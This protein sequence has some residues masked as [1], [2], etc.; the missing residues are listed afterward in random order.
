[1]RCCER[2]FHDDYLQRYI[3]EHGCIGSCQFCRARRVHVMRAGDLND[4]F[5]RFTELYPR[6]EPGVNAPPDVDV[7]ERGE[8]LATI[9][10]EQWEIFSDR[11][12]E[13]DAH[14]DLLNKIYTENCIEEDILDAPDMHE[15]Y[16]ERNWLHDSLLDQWHELAEELKHPEEHRPFAPELEPSE[17]DIAGAVDTLQWFEEDIGRAVVALPAGSQIYRVRLGYR[18][19]DYRLV[20]YPIAEVGAP[21][22]AAVTQP[23]R[24]N[25][26]GVS[27]FYAADDERTAV[28]EKRPHRGA[29]VTVATGQ[30]TRELHLV[31]LAAGMILSSPFECAG[32]Y[33]PSLV[34]SCELFNHLNTEFAKPLRHTDDVHEYLPTQFF[35]EWVRE[36]H[37]DGIR[38]SSAMSE[39]GTNI[40]LFDTAVVDITAVR[41]VRVEAVEVKYADYDG[42]E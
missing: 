3:H 39:G 34:E 4:L 11:L 19:Q 14:H 37:Y 15:L 33:L 20:A 31:D 23:G 40:V 32:E 38:Y 27:Y 42:E 6:L 25:P 21:P 18:E 29:L 9:I 1:M 2:C 7:L 5:T 35:A 16:T 10:Q 28:A 8:R 12:T 36:H 17:A 41:L 24:A 22:A 13:R 26:V 30:T